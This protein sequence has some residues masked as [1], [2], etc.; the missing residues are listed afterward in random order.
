MPNESHPRK[1]ADDTYFPLLFAFKIK[2][3]FYRVKK[4]KKLPH[5]FC[6][7]KKK[8]KTACLISFCKKWPEN[9][10][11]FVFLALCV[12]FTLSNFI[13]KLDFKRAMFYISVNLCCFPNNV[14]IGN[15][16]INVFKGQK[17]FC[18]KRAKFQPLFTSVCSLETKRTK[19]QLT[20]DFSD[21]RRLPFKQSLTE[22]AITLMVLFCSRRPF[23]VLMAFSASAGCL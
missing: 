5:S 23:R 21:S 4:K 14:C 19:T 15:T 11:P 22:A 3:K 1:N 17:A 18:R 9:L 6:G 2:V 7:K 13:R 20:S 16:S 8:K 12:F 10:I